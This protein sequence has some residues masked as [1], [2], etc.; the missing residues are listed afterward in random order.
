M[1]RLHQ[2]KEQMLTGYWTRFSGNPEI[3]SGNDF[4]SNQR[5]PSALWEHKSFDP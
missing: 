3:F 5:K 1:G 2:M 4:L